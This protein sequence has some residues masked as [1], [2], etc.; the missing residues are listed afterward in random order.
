MLIHRY[1]INGFILKNFFLLIC[2]ATLFVFLP[3]VASA[4]WTIEPVDS[5]KLFSH[6]YQ[7]AIAVE[8]TTNYPHIAYGGDNLYHAYFDGTDWKY[9]TVDNS[10]GAGWATSIA[11]GPNNKVY[12]GYY[13]NGDLKYA[14]NASGTWVTKTIDSEGGWYTSLSIDSN[15]KVHISYCDWDWA[16]QRLKY[17]TN[18]SGNWVTKTIDNEGGFYTSLFIDSNNKVHISY[19]DWVNQGLKYATNASGAWVTKTIDSEGWG[20][21]TSI[22]IDSN[23]KVHISYHGN[24][25]LKYS[26]SEERR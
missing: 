18:A 19:C 14:T 4:A 21:Y 6:S 5:P 23:N 9:E 20:W 8:K 15:N 11:I 13:G 7:R 2:A 24:Y 12:I 26:R 3:C 16:T 25:S 17:A 22:A 1:V 10:V